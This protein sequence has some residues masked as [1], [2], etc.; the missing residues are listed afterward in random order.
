MK[1][2]RLSMAAL[3]I[4]MS[5]AGSAAV[6]QG[7]TN[8]N[9]GSGMSAVKVVT[10]ENKKVR[11][12]TQNSSPVDVSI[13]DTDGTVLYQGAITDNKKATSFNLKNLPDGQY[14]ITAGT[15]TWWMSQGM[16]VRGN[17]V[18]IDAQK[19][20][21]VAQPTLTAYEKNKI[22]MT[23]PGT[24]AAKTNVIIY[25]AQSQAVYQDTFNGAVRRF[26]LTAL[27]QGSYTFVVGPDQKQFTSRIDVR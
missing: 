7:V 21:Q 27:P 22:E 15:N 20:Q 12:Y 10:S 23:L 3:L 6:A 16:T 2:I 8:A 18:S 4:S 24:N 19:L 13:I 14:F 9:D 25:D 1:Q 5:M 26:D 17:A 11:L